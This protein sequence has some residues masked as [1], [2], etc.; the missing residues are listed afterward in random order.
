PAAAGVV[1]EP[2]AKLVEM[3]NELWNA[4]KGNEPD[5]WK[6]LQQKAEP[7]LLPSLPL[8]LN[9]LLYERAASDPSANMEKPIP[10]SPEV[11]PPSKAPPAEVHYLRMLRRDAPV[12]PPFAAP[13]ADALREALSVRR[14]AERAAVGLEEPP[15]RPVVGIPPEA[16]Y[17]YSEYVAQ[18]TAPQID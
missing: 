1:S 3:V 8:R 9:A 15:D 10:L 5:K 16:R 17:A 13:Y 12:G 14:Q 2:S 6:E 4:P 11:R 18:W 7:A